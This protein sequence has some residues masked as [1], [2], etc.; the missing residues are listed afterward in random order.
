MMRPWTPDRVNGDGTTTMRS[1]RA[2]NGCGQLIGD[3]T[4]QETNRVVAGLGLP[5][6]RRECPTCGPTAP[7]PRCLPVAVV[8]GASECL[9]GDCDHD[10]APGSDRCGQFDRHTVCI[11]HSTL[12]RD[13]EVTHPSPWPCKHT[14]PEGK[15]R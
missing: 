11:T 10:R 1:K 4:E 13:G 12:G 3:V 6:V 7:P 9:S 8:G 15:T 14:I 2:C 5:D